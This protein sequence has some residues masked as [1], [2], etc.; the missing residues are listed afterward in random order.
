MHIYLLI[1]THC[2]QYIHRVLRNA[3]SS[4]NNRKVRKWIF[5]RA[6][7]RHLP[8]HSRSPVSVQRRDTIEEF[9]ERASGDPDP[10]AKQGKRTGAYPRNNLKV[11]RTDTAENSGW[12]ALYLEHEPLCECFCVYRKKRKGRKN[13]KYFTANWH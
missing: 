12:S 7:S 1:R 11:Q 4:T 10:P 8:R 2:G 3:E 5:C 6:Q 13:A 9:Q